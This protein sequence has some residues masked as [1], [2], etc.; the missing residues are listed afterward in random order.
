[1]L[2]HCNF[3]SG[4]PLSNMKIEFENQES[5]VAYAEK[6]GWKWFIEAEH[7]VKPKVKSYGFNFSWDK[8]SRVST[9]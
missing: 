5:A 8:R 2:I 3:F 4:D 1:M 9:K 7:P 6:N